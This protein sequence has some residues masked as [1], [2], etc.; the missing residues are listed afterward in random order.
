MY[1]KKSNKMELCIHEKS[2]NDMIG[3]NNEQPIEISKRHE[4]VRILVDFMIEHFGS[5]PSTFEKMSTARAATII[6]PR[7]L[8]KNSTITFNFLSSI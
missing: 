1:F 7:L 3:K 4:L 2:F 6:F 5:K 8:F